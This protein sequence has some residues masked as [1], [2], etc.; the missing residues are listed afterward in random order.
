MLLR[1]GKFGKFLGCSGYPDCKN[2]QPLQ[3]PVDLGIKC[4]ECK[5]GNIKERKSRWGKM[6]YGCDKY[7]ECKFAT[8]DK[9]M[10]TP[11]PDCDSPILVEKVT[12]A[13]PAAATAATK[14]SA[15]TRFKWPNN[16]AALAFAFGFACKGVS[17]Q[18]DEFAGRRHSVSSRLVIAHL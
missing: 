17:R 4:P 5:E 11:C 1:F 18:V 13:R 10:P 8:W 16:S 15:A 9:P 7:P 3:K 14:K 12:Q 2:I 6:F